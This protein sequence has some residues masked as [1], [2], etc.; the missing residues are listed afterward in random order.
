MSNFHNEQ[1]G[2]I[3]PVKKGHLP[4]GER[5]YSQSLARPTNHP[6]QLP[7]PHKSLRLEPGTD[8]NF[9]HPKFS[10]R[11]QSFT[12]P[13]WKDSVRPRVNQE[14][15][16]PVSQLLT[17]PPNFGFP[18]PNLRGHSSSSERPSMQSS[19]PDINRR[20]T[21]PSLQTPPEIRGIPLATHVLNQ[22][23]G[24]YGNY[25]RTSGQLPSLTEVGIDSAYITRSDRRSYAS[26]DIH[27]PSRDIRH[28]SE[29]NSVDYHPVQGIAEDLLSSPRKPLILPH[30]VD[31]RYIPGE[32]LCYIYADGSHCPKAIDGEPVNA[33]WGITKAGKPRK[34]LAQACINCREKK[35]KCQPNLPKCDQC[36]K[37]GRECRFESAPRGNQS[38]RFSQS[39]SQ[40]M[41]YSANYSLSSRPSTPRSF[42]SRTVPYGMLQ[43]ADGSASPPD[44]TWADS[45]S[46]LG[47]PYNRERPSSMERFG[48]KVN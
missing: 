18:S 19:S 15:L 17:P 29:P 27:S 31:E 41:Q 48:G 10:Q 45:R 22:T 8:T 44:T 43:A 46:D 36:Q 47:Q 5:T 25:N 30:V 39:D 7:P 4:D 20:L 38:L 2:R 37:S 12:G 6:Y 21:L 28:V 32:G 34:R 3:L 42:H 1:S 40:A 33:S 9:Q 26:R 23:N 11:G 16:P 14:Q 35:I 24:I 13:N